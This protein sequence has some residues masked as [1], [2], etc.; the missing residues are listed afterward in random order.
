[1]KQKTSIYYKKA[2]I[3]NERGKWIGHIY[4]TNSECFFIS[5][6]KMV[7]EETSLPDTM[8]TSSEKNAVR[9]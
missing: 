1:M 8:S 9:L 3:F 6:P 5:E 7:A 2:L 4:E